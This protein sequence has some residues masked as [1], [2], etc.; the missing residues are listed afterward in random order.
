MSFILAAA[1][2]ACGTSSSMA[3]DPGDPAPV[4]TP[5]GDPVTATIGAAGGT[6]TSGDGALSI[7]VP[8]GAVASDTTFSIQP[9]TNTTFAPLGAGYRLAPSDLAFA[10]PVTLR[11]SYT[12]DELAGTDPEAMTIAGQD[13]AGFWHG[14]GDTAL[15]AGGHT[16]SLDVSGFAVASTAV[17]ARLAPDAPATADWTRTFTVRVTPTTATVALGKTATFEV[18]ECFKL[19]AYGNLATEDVIMRR[20]VDAPPGARI[21]WSVNE[22]SSAG[23]AGT[24]VGNGASA[25][26]TAPQQLYSPVRVDAYVAYHDH[27]LGYAALVTLVCPAGHRVAPDGGSCAPV[28]WNGTS[29]I[30]GDD[31]AVYDS[32]FVFAAD[33]T[34]PGAFVVQS[35]EVN[36][37]TQPPSSG[38]CTTTIEAHHAI[39]SNDG[40]LT[41][42]DTDY[43][44]P[45]ISGGGT[46]VWTATY[47]ITCPDGTTTEQLPYS[48]A[49]WPTPETGPVPVTAPAGSATVPVSGIGGA[50]TVTISRVDS[51]A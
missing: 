32:S 40:R 35:G 6:L 33:P 7:V 45:V 29:H 8:P 1:L 37:T 38:D 49:W 5:T 36:I 24:V 3:T 41:V 12:D 43:N 17:T 9:I 48:I 22:D 44:N 50:G 13:P 25:K 51:G 39:A 10:A 42:D 27:G 34:I 21:E 26:Y 4:G 14:R 2:A 30:T 18:H 19:D 28:T 20:C 31:G 47:T 23:M 11:F 16:V 46:T 15:D